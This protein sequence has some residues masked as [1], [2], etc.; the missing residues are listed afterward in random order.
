MELAISFVVGSFVVPF[1]D[2]LK[3][4]TGAS[5][6]VALWLT[7]AVCFV[8]GAVLTFLY[9]FTALTAINF[10]D[11]VSAFDAIGKNFAAVASIAWIVFRSTVKKQSNKD[12][13]FTALG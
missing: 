12:A 8:A 10:G 5:D 4:A 13:D 2:W 7:V 6:L 1:V 11:P 3:K 9:N